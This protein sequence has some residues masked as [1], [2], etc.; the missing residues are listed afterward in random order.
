MNMLEGPMLLNILLIALPLAATSILQM[1][2]NAA[3][4]AVVG[5]FAGSL[6]LA[7]VGANTT[8]INLF[9]NFITGI[10]VGAN[11]LISSYIGRDEKKE[12]ASAVNS[13]MSLALV[14]GIFMI[15][16]GFLASRPL[17]LL[18]SCPENVF[19][20][21]LL[22]LRLYMVGMPFIILF[23]FGSAILRSIGDTRRPLMALIFSGIF[24]VILNIILVVVCHMDVAG[25]AIATVVSNII[26]AGIVV[27]ILLQED[28]IIRWNILSPPPCNPSIAD[29]E[30]TA[31]DL[32]DIQ[33]KN[34]TP[35][36]KPAL[37]IKPHHLKEILYVGGP[38]GLQGSLFS[39]SNLVLQT[40]INSLGA[41]AI[42][43]S[44]TALNYEYVT[45]YIILSF[46]ST[47]VT[48]ASQNHAAGKKDRCRRVYILCVLT[49]MLIT[50]CFSG[51]FIL[52]ESSLLRLFTTDAAVLAF[53]SIRMH[54]VVLLEAFTGPFEISAGTLRGIGKSISP[55]VVSILGA[56]VFR[57]F[58]MQT[59]FRTYHTF[60][61][62]M[63]VYIVSWLLMGSIL[64]TESIYLLWIKKN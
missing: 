55:S 31:S 24:N 5:R 54:H 35:S 41:S 44:S 28:S 16:I 8:N 13:I 6:A 25:V 57:I 39:I 37:S 59:V 20:Q 62:I 53:A 38:S 63:N 64:V 46:A 7:A 26:S 1:L 47:A 30:E 10:A 11:V 50:A 34:V 49:G 42:A 2:F 56:C 51:I 12:V 52:N 32:A 29:E 36:H 48:Y 22:Y 23:N 19:D 33:E 15:G 60:A 14:S 27:G 18:T 45:Y 17:L 43:G 3:D 4:V 21:A 40:G 58:W 61:T 9:V